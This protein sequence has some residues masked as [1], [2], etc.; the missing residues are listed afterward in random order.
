MST[1]SLTR[2]PARST[3]NCMT[4]P[5]TTGRVLIILQSSP[6]RAIGEVEAL[7]V[8]SKDE[9]RLP[10]RVLEVDMRPYEEE[11]DGGVWRQ[12]HTYLR[13]MAAQ[14]RKEADEARD[15]RMH[16]LG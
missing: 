12:A 3:G 9:D 5:A 10:R 14:I 7:T 15:A 6:L 1:F 2:R 16:Y 8:L 13:A 11:V 4:P